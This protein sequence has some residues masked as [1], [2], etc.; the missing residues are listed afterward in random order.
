MTRIKICGL[1]RIEDIHIVNE[2]LPDY[3]GFVFA[4]G[5]RTITWKEA[6]KLKEKL[7]T[8][9]QAA[10][11]YVNAP[12]YDIL[13][14]AQERIIDIIQ[15]HGEENEEYILQL[16]EQTNL[17]II[18]A[19]RVK[20]KEEIEK[21]QH[22][23]SDYLLLDSY[24]KYQYGGSGKTFDYRLIPHLE[25]PFFL[26]GGLGKDNIEYAIKDVKPFAVD[27]SSHVEVDGYKDRE[28]VRELIET[29]RHIS[30]Q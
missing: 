10:G 22:I 1:R 12:I 16:K 25:K 14:A 2:Y 21:S 5:K 27:I 29:V 20:S 28:K 18:K 7:D 4:K 6:A 30:D 17:P 26:A 19:I 15:L 11:V 24:D 9:I 8:R 23:D 13:I 3:I